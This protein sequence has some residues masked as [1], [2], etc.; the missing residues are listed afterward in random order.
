MAE[1]VIN[2]GKRL[3]GEIKVQGSKNSVLPILAATYLADGESV[4]HNCPVLSDV[5]AAVKILENF[6]CTAVREGSTLTLMCEGADGFS[7]PEALMREMRSSVVFLGAVLGKHGKAEITLPGGCE[8]GLRP[9]DLHIYAIECLGARV[10][11]ENGKLIF[12]AENGLVGNKIDF[13]FQ[14]VGATENAVLTAVTA[15]GVTELHNCA[16][17]PEIA[18]LCVFLNSCGA[19]ITGIGES[20][21]IIEGVKSLRGA[22]HTVI[23]DRIVAATYLVGAAITGSNITVLDT[24]PSHL[25]AVLRRLRQFGCDLCVENNCISLKAP[26]RL[27]SVSHIITEQYPGFPTDIQ[28]PFTVLA[29]LSDGKTVITESIFESRFKHVS[30]LLKMGAKISAED[31]TEV[32][33]GVE[34]LYGATVSARDLRGGAALVLAGLAAEGETRVRNIH[35]IDRGYE[36]FEEN[37]RQL[38]AE[39]FRK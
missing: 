9:I 1:F 7:I 22:E 17:E 20:D 16:R 18:D 35:F 32:I 33:D 6:G 28:A 38:N 14:S 29:A 23:S 13:P 27:R 12:N 3:N 11:E 39:I 37:L 19:K 8:I 26:R 10:K 4:I 34:K 30:E 31:R 36:R 21:I 24:E 15:K 25:D 2:G 5:S